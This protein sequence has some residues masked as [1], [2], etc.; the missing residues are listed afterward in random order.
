MAMGMVTAAGM[1]AGMATAAETA[2]ETATAAGMVAGMVTA[3]DVTEV[4]DMELAMATGTGMVRH[5]PNRGG[6]L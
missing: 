4:T 1:A 3:T 2:A 5:K 6:Q